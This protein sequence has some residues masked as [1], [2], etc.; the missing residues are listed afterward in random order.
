[1][2]LV[3]SVRIGIGFTEGG[4]AASWETDGVL[5]RLEFVG[6]AASCVPYVGGV[7]LSAVS[8]WCGSVSVVSGGAQVR[9]SLVGG[10]F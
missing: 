1:M 8:V 6:E 10:S 3:G 5:G 9:Q 2:L 7:L 4:V